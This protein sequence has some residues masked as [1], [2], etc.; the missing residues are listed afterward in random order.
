MNQRNLKG[1]WPMLI[2]AFG[3]LVYFG[4]SRF[5]ALPDF[6]RGLLLGIRVADMLWDCSL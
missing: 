6:V 3:T 5:V 2:G 4:V 1:D